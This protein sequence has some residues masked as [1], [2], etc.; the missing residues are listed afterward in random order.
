MVENEAKAIEGPDQSFTT[1]QRAKE[2]S[3]PNTPYRTGFSANLP[4][5][6]AYE[7]VTPALI[8]GASPVRGNTT[9]TNSWMV[10]PRGAG[11][12]QSLAFIGGPLPG[13]EGTGDGDGY[14][15]ARASGEHPKEGWETELYSPSYA[16]AWRRPE[17]SRTQSP[18]TTLLGLQSEP[19]QPGASLRR[20]LTTLGE[21]RSRLLRRKDFAGNTTG[22]L[23][24][25]R[26]RPSGRKPPRQRRRR[27]RLFIS[28]AHLEEEAPPTGDDGDYDRDG[29]NPH[30]ERRAG[31][32]RARGALR[33]AKT[34]T[35]LGSTEDGAAVVFKA[36]GILYLRRGGETTAIAEAPF[37]FAGISEDGGRVFF[38]DALFPEDTAA[39]TPS[40][41]LYACDPEAGPCVG[42]GPAGLTEIATD[43]AF[44]NV[45]SDGSGG[46]FAPKRLTGAERTSGE[47]P[48]GEPHI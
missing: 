35:D 38:M 16:P 14:R 29:R 48:G 43:S 20:Y 30:S 4:D 45:S 13:F 37:T 7:L 46:L 23:R 15:A 25:A 42:S 27:S 11:A 33:P 9:T 1:L 18:Q 32:G 12:G 17:T 3:C 44:V 2:Q 8:Q 6:R 21:G 10:S 28:K 40:A 22:R 47:E 26:R 5:C 36:G 24:R 34:H 41:T 31:L 39:P 19:G